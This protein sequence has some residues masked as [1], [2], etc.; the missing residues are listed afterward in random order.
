M[1]I[2][3]EIES[4][5][6]SYAKQFPVVAVLGPRQSGKTTIVQETFKKHLYFSLEDTN[7]RDA[8]RSDPKLFIESK[9]NKHGVIIDEVQYVPDLFSYIQIAADNHEKPG[10]FILTGS[11]NYL[12]NQSISQSLAGRVG[13]LTL[14]PLSVG[15][16]QASSL[17]PDNISELMYKGQYPRVY[18]RNVQPKALYP[19]YIQTYVE[20]DVRQIKN[21]TD[22]NLFQTFIR[23]CAGRIGQLLNL[24]SLSN[25]CGISVNTAKEW[26]S[27]LASSYI[28]FLLQ[29][30]HKNFS[31]R[32]I[33]SPKLYFYDTG[34][35]CSLL[36]MESA[37][38]LHTHYIRGNLFESFIV[39]EFLKYLLNRGLQPNLYFWRD[40]SG[41]EVDILIETAEKLVP[42]EIKSGKTINSSFFD[43]LKYWNDLAKAAPENGFLIYSGD[44][45]QQRSVGNVV[46]WKSL[47]DVFDK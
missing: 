19:S 46:G 9:L 13:I 29:P 45:N 33:K 12:L 11:Q 47:T 14:L 27:L 15:E 10:Y 26:I 24:T 1:V 35:A 8:A 30:H 31:K 28:I 39:S 38:Q 32:L 41:H 25:D 5:L 22:L 3:R 2:K 36:R 23:L 16:L 34:L 44:E 4:E 6:K 7:T 42:V 21:V 18:A 40:R 17:R 43:G 37:E 20:R